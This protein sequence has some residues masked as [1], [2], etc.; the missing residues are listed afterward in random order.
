MLELVTAAKHACLV[1]MAPREDMDAKNFKSHCSHVDKGYMTER[2]G[3]HKIGSRAF[4]DDFMEFVEHTSNDRWPS[5][6]RDEKARDQ[7]K[8]GAI[9]L[10][11]HGHLVKAATRVTGL[12]LS[13]F[14]WPSHGTRHMAALQIASF[15]KSCVVAVRSDSGAV[16]IL[17]KTHGDDHVDC[18]RVGGEPDTATATACSVAPR[19]GESDVE[20]EDSSV[21]HSIISILRC[22]CR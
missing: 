14:A 15:L 5:D 8:D 19:V 7:P 16:H 9:I 2:L 3:K 13:A 17:A 20:P 11:C 21:I 18:W 1:V 12:P 4:H 10:D 6:Y 22:L